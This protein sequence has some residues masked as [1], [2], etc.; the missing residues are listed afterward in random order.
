MPIPSFHA[1]A[2]EPIS[3]KLVWSSP[4]AG[5]ERTWEI[6]IPPDLF[7]DRS[8]CVRYV[9]EQFAAEFGPSAPYHAQA[10]HDA[11]NAYCLT[12]HPDLFE[13]AGQSV[14]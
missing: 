14:P 5:L 9:G 12:N 10:V 1:A 4:V 7:R 2:A 13:A 6:T 11:W 8:R 3:V